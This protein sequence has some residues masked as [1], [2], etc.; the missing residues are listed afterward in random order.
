M[1][2]TYYIFNI[3]STYKTCIVFVLG[4]LFGTITEMIKDMTRGK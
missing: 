4:V 2:V 3:E 1:F